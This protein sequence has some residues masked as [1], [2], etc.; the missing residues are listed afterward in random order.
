MI[1]ACDGGPGAIQSA[2]ADV[3]DRA[4]IRATTAT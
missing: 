2:L 1:T 3:L 4:G